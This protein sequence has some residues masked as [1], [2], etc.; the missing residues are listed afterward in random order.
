MFIYLSGMVRM[1]IV[2]RYKQSEKR[3]LTNAQTGLN[4][5]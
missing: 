1:D 4:D 3:F 2:L 5:M